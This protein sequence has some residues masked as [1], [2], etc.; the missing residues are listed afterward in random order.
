MSSKKPIDIYSKE[1]IE[2]RIKSV[3]SDTLVKEHECAN[4]LATRYKSLQEHVVNASKNCKT[5]AAQGE[6][7]DQTKERLLEKV[8][9]FLSEP[10]KK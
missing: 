9:K 2:K 5:T 6:T 1:E 3:I 7:P 4:S 8:D 10:W